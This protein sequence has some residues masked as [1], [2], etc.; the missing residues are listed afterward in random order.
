MIQ[1]Y[2]LTYFDQLLKPTSIKLE[3]NKD[4]ILLFGKPLKLT[5]KKSEIPITSL[6]SN[7]TD[8]ELINIDQI[9]NIFR[10]SIAKILQN[11]IEEEQ[12]RITPVNTYI[13][14]KRKFFI[15]Y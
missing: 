1:N 3:R 10:K 2:R 5:M 8:N 9:H 14:F 6:Y 13:K 7:R 12:Q 11:T 15:F 4:F